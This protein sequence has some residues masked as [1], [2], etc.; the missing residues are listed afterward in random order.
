MGNQIVINWA[1]DGK[2]LVMTL[3]HFVE[4]VLQAL[5]SADEPG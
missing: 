1:K 3:P 2:T 4:G 5:P